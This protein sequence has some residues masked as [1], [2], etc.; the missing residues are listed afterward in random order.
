M[1]K[2]KKEELLKE[3]QKLIELNSKKEKLNKIFDKR[4]NRMKRIIIN[5]I[6][7][8]LE[9]KEKDFCINEI[10]EFWDKNI[11]DMI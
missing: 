8:E 11:L 10:S 6:Y 9:K 2:Q 7:D 5:K 1:I 4:V 3:E